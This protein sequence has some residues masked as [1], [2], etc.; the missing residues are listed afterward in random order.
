MEA[1][2]QQ[3][4]PAVLANCM[5][6]LACRFSDRIELARADSRASAGVEYA[7]MS[8]VR[9]LQPAKSPLVLS[10]NENC[11]EQLLIVHMLSWPSL[12]VLQA[13]V[14]IAWSEFGSGRD[15]GAYFHVCDC[16]GS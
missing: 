2:E 13:L 8:K 7:D 14:L 15:S 10:S 6:S 5:A 3:T 12:E 11:L 9:L 16:R 4:L 1:A